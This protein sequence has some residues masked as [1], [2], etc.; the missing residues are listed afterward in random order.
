MDL[1]DPSIGASDQ[2][3][4][5]EASYIPFPKTDA[6]REKTRGRA[7]P[8]ASATPVTKTTER[9]GAALDALV[10]QRWT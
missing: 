6:E 2:Q 7:S 4:S 1:R 5:F 8:S 10:K 3:V 9:Y